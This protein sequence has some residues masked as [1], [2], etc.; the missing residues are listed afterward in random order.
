MKEIEEC[1]NNWKGTLCHGKKELIFLKWPKSINKFKALPVR[2]LMPWFYRT[3][4]ND[5]KICM[6]LQ[7]TLISQGNLEKEEQILWHHCPEFKF[8][9]QSEWPTSSV[10]DQYI[11]KRVW[12]KKKTSYIYCGNVNWYSHYVKCYGGSLKS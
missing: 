6:E 8:Y 12:G 3:R 7:H 1:R 10:Y 11:L 9:F 5:P 4:R 2:I